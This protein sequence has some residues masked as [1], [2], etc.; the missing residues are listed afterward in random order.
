MK[1]VCTFE[2]PGVCVGVGTVEQK[3]W[4]ELR[5]VKLSTPA[6]NN[7]ASFPWLV[8]VRRH[9]EK[10]DGKVDIFAVVQTYCRNFEV[11]PCFEHYK[12]KLAQEL[13]PTGA[14]KP[15]TKQTPPHCAP[16]EKQHDDQR[17][18]AVW[19][20][21]AKDYPRTLAALN[22]NEKDA[23]KAAA[24]YALDVVEL[25]GAISEPTTPDQA[26]RFER[27]LA[28]YSK[29]RR[30]KNNPLHEAAD[31]ELLLRWFIAGYCHMPTE[32]IRDALNKKLGSSFSRA[33]IIK[34]YQR[35][36]LPY[37]RERGPADKA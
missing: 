26:Q 30:T 31:L 32:Q 18:R 6:K 14:I 8:E 34:R 3:K 25:T 10:P 4:F 24:E 17:Q 16:V 5:M 13:N 1:H 23:R 21:L 11:Q 19:A 33:A 20:K 28:E 22:R 12:K 2:I 35:L 9:E 37:L 15:A 7:G 29:R 27:A 36:N